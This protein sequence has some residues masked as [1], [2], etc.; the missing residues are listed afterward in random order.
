MAQRYPGVVTRRPRAWV[1]RLQ[2]KGRLHGGEG[3]FLL[4]DGRTAFC[5]Q[6]CAREYYEER[7][8]REGGWDADL[9]RVLAG[10]VHRP[11]VGPTFRRKSRWALR[12]VYKDT[13]ENRLIECGY[14][15]GILNPISKR[16]QPIQQ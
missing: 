3:T 16:P 9:E 5:S 11:L 13:P 12:T 1:Q 6:R 14:C 7:E 10:G 4:H 2:D 8:A 15:Y